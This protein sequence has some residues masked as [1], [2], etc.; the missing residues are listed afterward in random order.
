MKNAAAKGHPDAAVEAPTRRRP[1]EAAGP[2]WRLAVG[3]RLLDP[4]RKHA[5]WSAELFIAHVLVA[6]MIGGAAISAALMLIQP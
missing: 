2:G 3:S 5:M 4:R 1:H 6:V